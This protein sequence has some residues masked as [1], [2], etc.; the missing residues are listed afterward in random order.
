MIYKLFYV[1]ICFLIFSC[2]LPDE[3]EADC[4]GI[5]LGGAYLDDCGYCADGDT[6]RIPNADKDC[7]GE[8]FGNATE[9]NCGV[10]DDIE[11][12]NNITCQIECTDQDFENYNCNGITDEIQYCWNLEEAYCNCDL[13]ITDECGVCDGPGF[14]DCMCEY[15]PAE[16]SSECSS[17]TSSPYGVGQQINC[18]DTNIRMNLCAPNCNDDDDKHFSLSDLYGKVIFIEFTASW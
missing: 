18:N 5:N 17:N 6:G 10:C 2:D 11:S 15:I 14:I 13:A 4:N 1:V 3:A 9:D 7:L 12:N 16:S 8:C